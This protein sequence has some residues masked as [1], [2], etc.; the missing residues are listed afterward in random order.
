MMLTIID[1][2]YDDLVAEF[3]HSSEDF[4][5]SIEKHSPFLGFF[6]HHALMLQGRT[7]PRHVHTSGKEARPTPL[8]SP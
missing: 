2:R 3:Q 4:K 7:P 5:L 1:S 8:Q 6:V